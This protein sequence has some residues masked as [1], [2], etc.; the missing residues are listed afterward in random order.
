MSFLRELFNEH[1]K[2]TARPA[3][4]DLFKGTNQAKDFAIIRKN[5]HLHSGVK[6]AAGGLLRPH[7]RKN[8]GEKDLSE[9]CSQPR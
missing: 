3:A 1:Q 2:C 9:I 4:L 8:P 5:S 6:A 7:C